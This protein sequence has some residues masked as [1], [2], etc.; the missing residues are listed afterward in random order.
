MKK[1]LLKLLVLFG[2]CLPILFS[3]GQAYMLTV[4][5]DAEK[6]TIIGTTAQHDDI[7]TDW[8][9]PLEINEGE[10]VKL[11]VTPTDEYM[12]LY[13]EVS[14]V[15][16]L[17]IPMNN[18]SEFIEFEMPANDVEISAVLQRPLILSWV[19]DDGNTNKTVDDFRVH[20]VGKID[21]GD[22]NVEEITQD[23]T[24]LSHTYD[25]RE[26]PYEVKLINA[27]TITFD[28]NYKI[29]SV[30]ANNTALENLSCNNN[31]ITELT[32]KDNASLTSLSCSSNR[33]T[34]L[35][36]SN[37]PNLTTLDCGNNNLTSLNI[38]NNN[39]LTTLDCSD[40]SL[41]NLIVSK[42]TNLESLGCARN[43]LTSLDVSKNLSLSNL[44]CE[45]ESLKLL[46]LDGSQYSMSLQR[47]EN[48]KS[49]TM[50]Q[51]TNGII[52]YMD[53]T[54]CIQPNDGYA[55]TKIM[56][57]N[58]IE[59]EPTGID[60][61]DKYGY[62]FEQLDA[63]ETISANLEPYYTV[64]YY[65]GDTEFEVDRVLKIDHTTIEITTSTPE[66]TGHTFM[67]WSFTENGT[68]ADYSGGQHM[69]ISEDTKLYAVWKENATYE[70]MVTLDPQD[71]GTITGLENG[72][73]FASGSPVELTAHAEEGYTFFMWDLTGYE[74]DSEEEKNPTIT[75]NM[76]EKNVEV[77]ALFVSLRTITFYDEDTIVY[78]D[79]MPSGQEF[80][81]NALVE[82]PTRTGYRFDGW[83][84]EENGAGIKYEL[85]VTFELMDDLTLYANW[86]TNDY[87]VTYDANGGTGEPE[88]Q[89]KIIG[90]AL[91][92]TST[93]PTKIGYTFAGWNTAANGS[94]TSYVLGSTY[95]TDADIT[96][97]AQWEVVEY[98]I[99]YEGIEGATVSP[100]NPEKY[101]I[102]SHDITL[103]NP[104]KE[105]HNFLG[106]LGTEIDI[107]ENNV[108]ISSGS[109]GNREY[110]AIWEVNIYSL[111]VIP[112][113][114]YIYGAGEYEYN[115]EVTLE[116]QLSDEYKFI[117][118][119]SNS[120]KLDLTGET[121][122]QITFNM[123][124]TNLEI[125][126]IFELKKYT[127]TYDANGGSG[128]PEA[129]EKIHGQ[130]LTIP[131]D[132]PN[133]NGYDFCD[134]FLVDSDGVEHYFE[135]EGSYPYDT[136]TTLYARWQP[137]TYT[138]TY[139]NIDDATVSPANPIEYTIESDDITLTNPTKEGYIF[140]GWVGTDIPDLEKNVMISQGSTGDREYT[141]EW[142]IINTYKL[143]INPGGIEE[144]GEYLSESIVNAPESSY[145]VT[146]VDTSGINETTTKN[147]KKIFSS[148][149]LNGEG[150]IS[151]TSDNPV[152]YTFGAGDGTLEAT[153]Q[154]KGEAIVLPTFTRKGYSL[155]WSDSDNGE[156]AN[157]YLPGSSY[158]PS[159]DIT[160]YTKWTPEMFSITYNANDGDLA[161]ST[162]WG[163][164]DQAVTLSEETPKRE[165]YKFL[166]W[167]KTSDAETPEYQPGDTYSDAETI[168]LYA[169]WKEMLAI[170]DYVQY[171]P[172][173]T[174]CTLLATE[175]GAD[176]DQNFKTSEYTSGW[177]VFSNDGDT[178]QLIS[179]E[180]VGDLSLQGEIGY[181][182]IIYALNSLSR[183]YVNP[184]YAVS[185]RSI[186]CKG[187]AEKIEGE[188]GYQYPL[189]TYL[190]APYTETGY[191]ADINIIHSNN[192]IHSSG[193]SAWLASRCV[194]GETSG[195]TFSGRT[196]TK[197][198]TVSQGSLHRISFDDTKSED[199]RIAGVRPII[200]LRTGVKATGG[201]GTSES[202]WTISNGTTIYVQYNANGG[203]D[204]P[205]TQEELKGKTL[206]LSDKVPTREGYS[207]IG[208]ATEVNAPEVEYQAGGSF[209]ADKDTTLY[210]V[211]TKMES[212][213]GYNIKYDA[214][215]GIGGPVSQTGSDD[216][217]V[218]SPELP[219]KGGYRF[220]GWSTNRDATTAEYQPG[221]TYE[222]TK[223][224]TLYAVWKKR[225][226]SS[227]T[228]PVEEEKTYTIEASANE[229]GT[230][231]PKGTTTVSE[232]KNK[233]FSITCNKGYKI[234]KVL[235]DGKNVGDVTS[236]TFKD[237]T[238]NHTI[239]AVFMKEK[240]E[241][242]KGNVILVV[243]KT[244]NFDEVL[245]P[246][247]KLLKASNING[248]VDILDDKATLVV[249][250]I[251]NFENGSQK[252]QKNNEIIL[253]RKAIKILNDEVYITLD[254]FL[255][256]N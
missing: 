246:L 110:E 17:E 178:I 8:T 203:S 14:G 149:I 33:L 187:C 83:Y 222:G 163:S 244:N 167:A 50:F 138:I 144:E 57:N 100:A 193:D 52:Y 74:L 65:A 43:E 34:T 124:A 126:A 210:A 32:V 115:R 18:T 200:T 93:K 131:P 108:I 170:G 24:N 181:L 64:T 35:D 171:S 174:T 95:E 15:V 88:A 239:E 28:N 223:A 251:I 11:N 208:W 226:S 183:A 73:S 172:N 140:L 119:K 75:F 195:T 1:G 41:E 123:P 164:G 238:K 230:I 118:W 148:W 211:W 107:M 221:D 157:T 104:E 16:E 129:S 111:S 56:L 26:E 76:P 256:L 225:S 169:V 86:E 147:S 224:T 114:V 196:L 179:A 4:N 188:L 166:G 78:Q 165:G 235:V 40:N 212:V 214:N 19:A 117:G 89:T 80:E 3:V 48:T 207:F 77:R 137:I 51:P 45:Q 72:Y 184:E 92:L 176:I 253:L 10:F 139:L 67:G 136:D 159:G 12:F 7:I 39:S 189:T 106:W 199:A 153:Y 128:A 63:D 240:A 234:D 216:K 61:G 218:I 59:K 68:D 103:T 168:T 127:V 192:L 150:K 125:E 236:Y 47:H 245:L 2:I 37:N 206:T 70:V 156:G 185:G 112:N 232:G 241:L 247:S 22:G 42:Y 133:R 6:G 20:S 190:T 46:I 49:V 9:S 228:P 204:A 177:R 105:G 98:T 38:E 151:S 191:E 23:S 96:L 155:N 243:G 141:A 25:P 227:S 79:S 219:I 91:T 121:S 194:N 81:I 160:L 132:K 99:R 71:A 145:V 254:D 31:I 94:G 180:S 101:T 29:T 215:G 54:F 84:T 250:E 217:L 233:A 252:V 175:T 60:Y 13:W 85:G 109:T 205:D 53:E 248:K 161:P 154:S 229:G 69:D 134:W 44:N 197:A 36:V 87:T 55:V 130:Y 162:Q 146:F 122:T 5:T 182:N 158:Q 152:T 135:P 66:K 202:P 198:G 116:I 120:D 58:M 231:S 201:D 90:E 142:E 209:S 213:T 255:N 143:T 82:E 21:W 62:K 30:N 102:E 237:I 113:D 27:K 242:K 186:G 173:D 97:Y 249:E 220:L